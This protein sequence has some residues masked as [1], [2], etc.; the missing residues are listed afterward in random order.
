MASKAMAMIVAV[1]KS[2]RL[3]DSESGIVCLFEKALTVKMNLYDEIL[4]KYSAIHRLS[5]TAIP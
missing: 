4:F 2:F 1:C 3:D 5:I